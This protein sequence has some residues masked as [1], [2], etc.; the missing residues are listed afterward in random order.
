MTREQFLRK[1][2]S[3]TLTTPVTLVDLNEM[4]KDAHFGDCE[5]DCADLFEDDDDDA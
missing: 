5:Y 3:A 4:W 2:L 1:W